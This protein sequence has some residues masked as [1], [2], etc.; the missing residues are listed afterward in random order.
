[1]N[2]YLP[3]LNKC[4]NDCKGYSKFIEILNLYNQEV[5]NPNGDMS[6]IFAL[7]NH[8]KYFCK[9]YNFDFKKVIDNILKDKPLK[10]TEYI[11]NWIPI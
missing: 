2:D 10:Y 8:I 11:S 1:M 5:S 7:E 6:I 3:V 9:E 4:L